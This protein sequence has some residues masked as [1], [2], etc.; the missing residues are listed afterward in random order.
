[1]LYVPSTLCSGQR[2][3]LPIPL[4][5]HIY[6]NLSATWLRRRSAPQPYVGVTVTIV[7]DDYEPLCVKVSTPT[8]TC[9]ASVM[10]ETGCQSS[11]AGL[12]LTRRLGLRLSDLILVTIRMHIATTG[13]I[14][15]LGAD[16]PTL[17]GKRWSGPGPPLQAND[18][19]H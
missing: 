19:C 5:H 14:K 11:V 15:I 7:S 16:Y 9:P 6:D 13:G 10:A 12:K 2:G 1:M 18:L 8:M 3:G 17:F 4:D